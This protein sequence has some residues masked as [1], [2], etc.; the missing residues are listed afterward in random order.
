MA[1]RLNAQRTTGG[2]DEALWWV[3][4]LE[5]APRNPDGWR[6]SLQPPRPARRT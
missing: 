4:C 1:A 3:G 2:C 5:R 6:T